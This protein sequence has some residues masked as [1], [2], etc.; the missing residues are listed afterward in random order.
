VGTDRRRISPGAVNNCGVSIVFTY[1]K[2]K[3]RRGQMRPER[4]I[5]TIAMVIVVVC[6]VSSLAG[7]LLREQ[8]HVE[9]AAL[10]ERLVDDVRIRVQVD[11]GSVRVI[12]AKD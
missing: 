5:Q 3:R 6:A 12:V 7:D 2:Q 11:G 10:V 1:E 9:P 4:L 8:F